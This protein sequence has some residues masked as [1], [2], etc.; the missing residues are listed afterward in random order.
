MTLTDGTETIG[1]DE[2]WAN[3]TADM[4]E[5]LTKIEVCFRKDELCFHHMIFYGSTTVYM[6]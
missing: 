2:D 4:P 5:N 6:G 1:G 3:E